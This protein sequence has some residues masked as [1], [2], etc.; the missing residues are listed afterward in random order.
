MKEI[1]YAGIG[2]RETPEDTMQLMRDV[3]YV[4]GKRGYT[5]RSGGAGGADT[6]F[7]KGCV[8]AGGK[9]EIYLPWKKFNNNLSP[10]YLI[11]PAAVELAIKHHP[12]GEKL[13][14]GRGSILNLMARNG[15]QVLGQNLE[16][17]SSFVVCYTKDQCISHDKR[18]YNTGGTGQA[19]TIAS[20]NN[21]PIYNLS[22]PEHVSKMKGFLSK[23]EEVQNTKSKLG[24]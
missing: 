14:A 10:L 17:P 3:A 18:S 20:L 16:T 11:T 21:I 15:Y 5:L 9:K 23:F 13:R 2:S 7:E 8:A 19:I 1:F 12:S 4:L 22:I 6:A 24:L